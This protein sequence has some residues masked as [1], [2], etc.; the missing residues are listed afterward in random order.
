MVEKSPSGFL[1][2]GFSN[3]VIDS[4][5]K[6]DGSTLSAVPESSKA[7]DLTIIPFGGIHRPFP[8]SV[9]VVDSDKHEDDGTGKDIIY[10]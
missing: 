1:A 10:I 7:K 5:M 6:L 8:K 4:S 2:L 3:S 9:G